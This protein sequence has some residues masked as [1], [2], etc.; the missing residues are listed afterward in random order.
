[1]AV[2]SFLRRTHEANESLAQYLG[3]IDDI[4]KLIVGWEQ[5][6]QDDCMLTLI[7]RFAAPVRHQTHP[8]SAANDAG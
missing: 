7:V 2:N 8:E 3:G 4:R 6:Q 5:H 1:M